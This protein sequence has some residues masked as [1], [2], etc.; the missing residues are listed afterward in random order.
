[1]PPGRP[2]PRPARHTVPPP[3]RTAGLRRELADPL[4][5]N[6]YALIANS[7]ATG[8]LGVV[9][10]LV[11]ARVYPPAAVGEAS[12]AYAAMNLLAGFTALNFNG[13]LTRFIPQAG[14]W[15]G[16]LIVRSYVVS[17]VASV[18]LAAGF[19]FTI[20]WWGP[21]YAELSGPV[22]G[23]I[24]TGCVLAWAIFT[25][26]DS[27]LI[28]LRGAFWVFLENTLFGVAKIVLLIVLATALPAHGGIYVSWMLPVVVAVPLINV[29]IFGS[30]VPRHVADTGGVRPPS[31]RQIGRFLAGDYSG[32]MCLL[33]TVSLVP[34]VVAARTNAAENAYFYVAWLIAGIVDM[35]GIN[36]GMS[37]TVEGAFEAGSL[38]ANCRKALRRVASMLLPC[39]VLLAVLA[40]WWL[41]LF[42]P[43]YAAHSAEVLELLAVATLPRAVTEV[44]LGALR[45]QNR[46]SLVAL[47]QAARAVLMLGLTV[48][49]AG[50][51]GTVGAGMA[52][53]ATQTVIAVGI[54][55]GL[56]RVLT[57][58]RRPARP[59][60]GEAGRAA[61]AEEVD[62]R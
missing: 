13:A 10:W 59:A 55:V 60:A 49:L 45:A 28:G 37:L 34:V 38:A 57:G 51:Y 20:R 62:T 36:M 21:S 26:Q 3:G 8:A 11:M 32:A 23:L 17:A 12:A 29:L 61:E 18:V 33:A 1:V 2:V 43:A 7:A 40:P 54:S 27:V 46:T 58:R 39:A 24:F 6:G 47:I 9:Y 50:T 4:A 56:W 44:Y 16:P 15:T 42:G 5:R 48:V 35:I 30:L 41:R 22:I 52:V 25:L 14:R 19:M 53:L 31:R